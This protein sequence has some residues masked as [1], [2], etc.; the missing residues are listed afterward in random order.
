MNNIN[1]YKKKN[2]NTNN[3][4]EVRLRDHRVHRVYDARLSCECVDEGTKHDVR[5]GTSETET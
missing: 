3:N 5:D 2:N 1:N 4:C